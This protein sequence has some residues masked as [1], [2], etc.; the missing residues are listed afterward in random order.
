VKAPKLEQVAGGWSV[1]LRCGKGQN[2]R[3]VIRLAREFETQARAAKM[4]ELARLL[5][6]A[7][8]TTEAPV[9]LRKAGEQTTAAGFA[10]VERYA[11][12][13][14]SEP[15]P[16]VNSAAGTTRK[17]VPTVRELGEDWVSGKLHKSWPDQ[18]PLKRTSADDASRLAAHIY[19]TIGAKRIDEVTLDDCEE[20]MRRIPE[21]AARSRR[22]IAGTIARIF[23]MAV[24]PLRFVERSPIPQGFA[25]KSAARRAY[26]YLYPDEDRRLLACTAL[27]LVYRLLWG[28][29]VREGMR[30]SE[31]LGLTWECLDL[32]RGAIRLDKNKT[33]DPR[34]WALDPGAAKALRVY[35]EHFRPEAAPTALVFVSPAGEAI[36]KYGLAELLRTHLEAIG[37][38]QERPE[39]FVTTEQRHR[40]RVHDLRGS[41]VTIS[42]ANGWSESRIADRTGH[43]SSAMINRY[44]RTARSF[45]ELD[46]G[47]PAPLSEAIPEL[48]QL[49][50]G[51]EPAGTGCATG[52]AGD[53]GF[54]NDYKRPQ[55]DSNRSPADASAQDS[56]KRD[57]PVTRDDTNERSGAPKQQ[58]A[59]ESDPLA[60]LASALEAAALAGQ[61]DVVRRLADILEARKAASRTDAQIIPLDTQR[62]GG[63]R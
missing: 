61:W 43:R 37:L 8:R 19:P 51:T 24:Y 15:A 55:R 13:L 10:E 23:R 22:H 28:V 5:V 49:A 56:A 26:A 47:T 58:G 34:S 42:L 12:D 32:K 63:S 18:I 17:N 4:A 3:F 30:E 35:R 6:R 9:I 25:P 50:A 45:A 16:A 40:I 20:I 38:K 14:C 44:K 53:G 48:A 41:M 7:G 46:L 54:L 2:P 33:D 31:A 39:L 59:P 1:R 52:C 57:A 29:L 21:S 62:R 11:L 36:S 60:A 27:P